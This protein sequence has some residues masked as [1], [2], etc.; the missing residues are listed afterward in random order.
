M[1]PLHFLKL[2]YAL[3][4]DEDTAITVRCDGELN[5]SKLTLHDLRSDILVARS[6][7][8]YALYTDLT[9]ILLYH[10]IGLA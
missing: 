6:A 10:E 5:S 4:F 7:A 2:S 3:S 8:E 9:H 1:T